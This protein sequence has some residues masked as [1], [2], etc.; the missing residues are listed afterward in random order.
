MTLS[1]MIS[2]IITFSIMTLSLM[3]LSIMTLSI[4]TLSIMTLSITALRIMTLSIMTFSICHSAKQ[5]MS[6]IMSVAN[7][8]VMQNVIWLSVVLLNVVAL[9][10]IDSHCCNDIRPNR[11]Y[12]KWQ[13]V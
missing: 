6:F 9:L 10:N 12:A 1:K 7:E 2:N 13:L 4:M 5:I 11:Q 3:T 8:P